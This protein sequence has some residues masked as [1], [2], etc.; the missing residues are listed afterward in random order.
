MERNMFYGKHNILENIVLMYFMIDIKVLEAGEKILRR[1]S[2]SV[3][4]AKSLV[5]LSNF[6]FD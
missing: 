1:A 3:F 5:V 6:V 4:N 2:S